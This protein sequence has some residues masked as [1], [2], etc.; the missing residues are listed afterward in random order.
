MAQVGSVLCG[1]QKKKKQDQSPAFLF[2]VTRTGIEPMFS[3]WEA[4][5]LTAWPT[6]RIYIAWLLYNK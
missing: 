2:L 5:V 4:N 1:A 6:S 3:A